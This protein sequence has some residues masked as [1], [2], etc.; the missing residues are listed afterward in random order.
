MGAIDLG[1]SVS[2]HQAVK[3][4]SWATEVEDAWWWQR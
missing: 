1:I 2:E 3:F 4:H